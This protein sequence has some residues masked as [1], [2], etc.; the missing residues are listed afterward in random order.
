MDLSMER[1][2]D[3]EGWLHG[4]RSRFDRQWKLTPVPAEGKEVASMGAQLTGVLAALRL[5]HQSGDKKYLD[6]G[7]S[8]GDKVIRYG[9]NQ[10]TGS[11]NDLLENAYPYRRLTHPEIAWWVQI[12]GSFLQ[13]QL[14]RVTGDQQYIANFRKSEEFF[15]RNFRDHELGG[16]YGILMTDGK[17]VDSQKASDS[18]WHTPY[19]EMEH[20]LLNYLYL[21]LYVHRTPAVLRFKL[22]GPGKHLVSFVDDP[23]V[24]IAAVTID[25]KPWRK[26]DASRHLVTIPE[27]TGHSVVVTLSPGPRQTPPRVTKKSS[28]RN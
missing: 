5:Y 25:G 19:H 27:G 12:Y 20:A 10:E 4:F 9:F 8:L 18:A 21:N 24:R 23:T 28:A 26:F 15:E 22:D 13:L 2:R 17:I 6:F 11:W 3:K 14:F 16:V 1:M 7:K